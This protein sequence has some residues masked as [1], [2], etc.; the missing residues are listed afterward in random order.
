MQ[1]NTLI[2]I[3]LGVIVIAGA[4]MA[5]FGSS[6][7]NLK[8]EVVIETSDFVKT[9][10]Q[11]PVKALDANPAAK[12]AVVPV[13]TPKPTPKPT[14]APVPT[15]KPSGNTMADIRLHNSATSCWSAIN[16]NVYDLTDWVN[17]HPGGK[18]QS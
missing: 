17:S 8:Q 9:A 15:P 4:F 7:K 12:P 5:V 13:P 2:S 10:D 11:Q 1:K 14:T 6:L 18:Q 3:G 16:G